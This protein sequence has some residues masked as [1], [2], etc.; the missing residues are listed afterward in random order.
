MG[1]R[2]SSQLS[3]IAIFAGFFLC[4]ASFLSSSREGKVPWIEYEI[5]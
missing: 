4:V 3:L 5:F 2:K 1:K